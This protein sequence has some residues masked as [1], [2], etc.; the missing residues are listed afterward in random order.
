MVKV[1]KVTLKGK[2]A[3]LYYGVYFYVPEN[4][5]EFDIPCNDGINEVTIYP[6]DDTADRSYAEVEVDHP[7][8]NIEEYQKEY[9]KYNEVLG[10][11]IGEPIKYPE[12]NRDAFKFKFTL[13]D[14]EIYNK[15][16]RN[17]VDPNDRKVENY[18]IC[19]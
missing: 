2:P 9:G 14:V 3:Y 11:Y 17:Y 6:G 18:N 5:D 1:E 8:Y 12:P 19:G 15:T 7:P 16:N 13:T 10:K 4:C